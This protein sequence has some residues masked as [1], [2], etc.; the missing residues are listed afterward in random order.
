[1]DRMY[2]TA[3]DAVTQNQHTVYC[4]VLTDS[5]QTIQDSS[6]RSDKEPTDCTM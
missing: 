2:K 6:R 5:G 1:L 3:E 4:E